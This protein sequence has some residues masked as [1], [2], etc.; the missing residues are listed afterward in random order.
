VTSPR[1]SYT[2]TF[3]QYVVRFPIKGTFYRAYRAAL[4][5]TQ[6]RDSNATA[7]SLP[8]SKAA[9]AVKLTTHL[10]L[11]LN[12]IN[13]HSSIL[14]RGVLGNNRTFTFETIPRE[15]LGR[16]KGFQEVEAPRISKLSVQEFG[17]VSHTHRQPLNP[18]RYSWYTFLFEPRTILKNSSDRT[19]DLPACSAVPQRTA[20]QRAH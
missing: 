13:L 7:E 19:R 18:R 11:V 14:L 4:G 1:V 8:E 16:P 9:G 12:E 20:P 3:T 15:G 6:F 5:P 10:H 2:I 17:N